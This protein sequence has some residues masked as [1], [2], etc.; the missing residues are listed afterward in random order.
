LD[1]FDEVLSTRLADLR[2]V[3]FGE[4]EELAQELE[5]FTKELLSQI[6]RPRVNLGGGPPGRAD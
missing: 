5:P 1:S 6:R 4:I 2:D 3:S